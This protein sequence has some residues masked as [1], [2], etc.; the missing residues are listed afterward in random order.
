MRTFLVTHTPLSQS[1]MAPRTFGESVQARQQVSDIVER[2]MNIAVVLTLLVA[3]CSLAV[4]SGGSLVERKR[5]FTLLRLTG[6]PVRTLYKVVLLEALLPLAAATVLAIGA[7]YG[8]AVVAATK[9]APKG[10]PIPAPS[11]S[12]YLTMALGLLAA[13]VLISGTLPFLSRLTRSDNARF[14]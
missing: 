13:L 1:G 5:P 3:G 9:I 2:I 7:G 8:L 10:T 12:Y 6:T 4:A 14:E 11:S